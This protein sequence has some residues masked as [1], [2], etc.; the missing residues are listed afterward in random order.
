MT[1]KALVEALRDM[2]APG[3]F[4]TYS[5]AGHWLEQNGA[6]LIT[7]LA[8]SGNKAP[9]DDKGLVEPVGDAIAVAWSSSDLEVA[10]L[11]A[12]VLARS[13][14]DYLARAAITALSSGNEV[15]KVVGWQPIETA[16]KVH[17]HMILSLN[18]HGVLDTI[19]WSNAG[20]VLGNGGWDDGLYYDID[21]DRCIDWTP[22]HWMPLPDPPASDA[23][24]LTGG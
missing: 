18:R 6:A 17:G 23:A 10:G 12:V 1:N 11:P 13:E 4:W 7:A 5:Q 16:P 21:D 3:S 20:G 19:C 24:T 9:G 15:A 8:S 14:R 2:T 22:T